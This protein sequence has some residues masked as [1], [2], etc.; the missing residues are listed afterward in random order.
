MSKLAEQ[1]KLLK[2]SVDMQSS[3]LTGGLESWQVP[4]NFNNQ[5]FLKVKPGA[6]LTYE[7]LRNMSRYYDIART[8]ISIKQNQI[9]QLPWDI[10]TTDAED[11]TDYKEEIALRKSWLQ[12]M[13]GFRQKFSKVLK[14]VIEDILV[15]DGVAIYKRR[16]LNKSL[17]GVTL[18]DPS[19]IKLRVDKAGMTPQPPEPA[20][21][22]WIRGTKRAELTADEMYYHISNPRSDSPYGYSIMEGLMVTVESSL[23]VGMFNMS[24]FTDGTMPEGFY[25]LP[26]EWGLNQIKS[27]IEA[28]DSMMAGDPK[29]MRK[30]R[31]M[32]A[33]PQG[34]GFTPA[35]SFDLAG[36]QPFMEWLMKITC[37][38]F[39]VMPQELGF[40]DSVNK[41]TS[42]E[43][44]EITKRNSIK[45]L[46]FELE[47][48]INDILWNND[49][50]VDGKILKANSN[51]KFIFDDLDPKDELQDAQI[52]E[53]HVKTGLISINQWRKE[54]GDDPIDGGDEPFIITSQGIVLIKDI[55]NGVPLSNP[56]AEPPKEP[57]KVSA[58]KTT[59]QEDLKLWEKKALHDLKEGRD[60]RKFE[61]DVLDEYIKVHLP[62]D[63]KKC[64]DKNE[65]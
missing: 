24:Y 10:T 32:P 51:L 23:K 56:P 41:A 33:S 22:Q 28:W 47:E 58:P 26:P 55:P 25:E 65:D 63:L 18:V 37:S 49:I 12:N 7:T 16:A 44:T 43:Q 54:K 62:E 61:S 9:T 1:T 20:F 34:R 38:A 29:N 14:K 46:A 2:A 30:I 31:F 35:K 45:A 11:K 42:E 21:E 4:L 57:E 6:S 27:Y 52:A 59:P 19:T 40:T 36:I 13:G 5:Y 50:L 8:C 17:M 53:T 39:G 64:T 48:M 15:I 3:A 60:F